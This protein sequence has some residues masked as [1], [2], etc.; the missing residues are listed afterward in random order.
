MRR[1]ARGVPLGLV[2]ALQACSPVTLSYDTPPAAAAM[3]PIQPQR[4]DFLGAAPSDD[5]RH[6]ANW[7]VASHD[8]DGLPFIIIDK[9]GA[10]V[11]VFDKDGQLLGATFALMGAAHGDNSVPGIGAQTLST[12]TP[13]ERTT[14]AG[15]FVAEL[16]RDLEHGVLW[17][18]YRDSISMHRV[19]LGN[20]GDHRFQ[21]LATASA[22]DKRITYGCIN[23]PLKFYN[24]VVMEAF[25]GTTGIV[26]ILPEVKTILEVFPGSGSTTLQTR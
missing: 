25:S 22:L 1:I 13:A 18:D 20:P 4:A 19:I 15:R 7:V 16:G 2:L 9:I 11:F 8:N 14:P 21:R 10:K 5:A 17:I 24:D 6:V 3:G 23:V 12:I 26:Y